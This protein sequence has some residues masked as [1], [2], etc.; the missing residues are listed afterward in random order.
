VQ[1]VPKLARRAERL[2]VF[3]R[4]P[5]WLLP[6]PDLEIPP[7]VRFFFR[8]VPFVQQAVRLGAAALIEAGMV[9]GV[10]Y[11][12]QLPLVTRAVER[13]GRRF[14][15]SQISDPDLREK[16]QPAYGFGCKRPSFSNSYF[17]TFTRENTELVT[18]PIERVT[19]R[20]VRTADDVERA[21]DTLVLATGF[22]V[23]DFG[24]MPP[25]PVVG[26]RGVELGRFWRERRFQA[27]EGTT[28]PGFP[29]AFT[30]F[31][32]YALTGSSWMFMVEYQARHV[33]RVIEE[34]RR[35]GATCAEV[36]AEAHERYFEHVL[37]R[38]RNTIFFNNSCATANSYYF[39]EHGDA[40]FLRPS[41]AVETWWRTRRFSLDD[42]AYA[43]LEAARGAPAATSRLAAA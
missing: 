8:R 43:T 9:L 1:L 11:N 4:T 32:P 42:Y 15:E 20:G 17:R 25:I 39:D 5:I 38:Q 36:R 16:L 18:E 6:K 41:L 33:V 12:R 23:S 3:Q 37:A 26:R 27:Y 31:G 34:A 7:L 13:A 22:L 28:V 2:H 30:L 21:V 35:R 14:L 10:V 24:N 40:P 29:N 19:A